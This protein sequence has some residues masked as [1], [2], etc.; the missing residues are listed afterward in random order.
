MVSQLCKVCT[1]WIDHCCVSCMHRKINLC[2]HGHEF[3]WPEL[4]P[5]VGCFYILYVGIPSL[6]AGVSRN[7]LDCLNKPSMF[8]VWCQTDRSAIPWQFLRKTHRWPKPFSWDASVI[9]NLLSVF[10]CPAQDAA[11]QSHTGR[12]TGL[13]FLP[14]LAQGLNTNNNNKKISLH[15]S[16]LT[17]ECREINTQRSYH[18]QGI[19]VPL[20]GK[21]GGYLWVVIPR[22]RTQCTIYFD[23]SVRQCGHA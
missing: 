15:R 10:L 12:L 13:W 5:L 16:W 1:L 23:L 3:S 21:I 18:R 20:G 11:Y 2:E 7:I 8:G 4:S 19:V 22:F 14:K 17:A 6:L 9:T